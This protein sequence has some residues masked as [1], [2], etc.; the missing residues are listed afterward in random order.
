VEEAR[1]IAEEK[2]R[3]LGKPVAYTVEDS[4]RMDKQSKHTLTKNPDS[5]KRYVEAEGYHAGYL[6]GHSDASRE[7]KQDSHDTPL[8]HFVKVCEAE[9]YESGRAEGVQEERKRILALLEKRLQ[10]WKRFDTSYAAHLA[11]QIE[12]LVKEI[13]G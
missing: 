13:G 8:E 4:R 7:R 5:L 2:A 9:S 6:Q 10:I 1:E 12:L 11:A 3:E